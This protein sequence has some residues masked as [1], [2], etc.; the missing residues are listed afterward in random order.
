MEEEHPGPEAR[1]CLMTDEQRQVGYGGARECS[2]EKEEI[3]GRGC[4][5]RVLS[6][7]MPRP[8]FGVCR[9]ALLL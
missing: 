9:A 4:Q 3:M 7:G 2:V 6:R 5:R 8:D 1:G